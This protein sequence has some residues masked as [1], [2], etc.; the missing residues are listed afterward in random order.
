MTPNASLNHRTPNGGLSWPGL[1]VR[2]TFSPARAKPSR[3]RGPVSSNVRR[4]THGVASR[5]KYPTP[6]MA[7]TELELASLKR[8]MDDYLLKN[9]PPPHIRPRF[10]LAYRVENQS[11]E[12]YQ[13]MPHRLEKKKMIEH[14][15]AKAT[16]VRAPNHWRVYW[17]RANGRWFSYEPRHT[18]STVAEFLEVVERDE[19][20]CFFG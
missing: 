3:R 8:E 12:I 11:I 1:A 14:S 18:V 16:Y 10:D 9:Q 4:H 6:A 17:K 2:G 15:A 7:F 5:R 13:I 20:A 19:H